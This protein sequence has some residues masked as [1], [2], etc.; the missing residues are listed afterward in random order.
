M[1]SSMQEGSHGISKYGCS[2]CHWV[3]S[4]CEECRPDY[5][6]GSKISTTVGPLLTSNFYNL[7]Y[8]TLIY[9]FASVF[10]LMV[11]LTS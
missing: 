7:C 6:M 11:S 5:G 3:S 2:M 1:L 10:I 8:K 9:Q 4:G